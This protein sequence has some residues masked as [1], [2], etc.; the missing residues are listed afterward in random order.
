MKMKIINHS[1]FIVYLNGPMYWHYGIKRFTA[2][3]AKEAIS[4]FSRF[5]LPN[6]EKVFLVLTMGKSIATTST[7]T[8]NNWISFFSRSGFLIHIS[9]TKFPSKRTSYRIKPFQARVDA[10]TYCRIGNLNIELHGR[11]SDLKER[12]EIESSSTF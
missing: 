8:F 12:I 6:P 2:E 5:V 11:R 1:T 4:K 7:Y 3:E 10:D 9:K